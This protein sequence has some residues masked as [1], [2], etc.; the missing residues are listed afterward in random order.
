MLAGSS[1]RMLAALARADQFVA[2]EAA[3][4]VLAAISVCE[5]ASPIVA[6]LAAERLARASS[7]PG[8]QAGWLAGWQPG[9][10]LCLRQPIVAG[11]RVNLLLGE[12]A[13]GDQVDLAAR[14]PRRRPSE[15]HSGSDGDAISP[16]DLERRST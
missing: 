16:L 11:A 8:R 13:A 3:A 14:G 10:L 5:R 12:R 4:A 7:Q 9:R 6:H 15:R 1:G 2:V